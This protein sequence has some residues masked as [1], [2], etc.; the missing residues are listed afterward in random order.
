MLE[1]KQDLAITSR[2]AFVAALQARN[3]SR[4][5]LGSVADESPAIRSCAVSG[6]KSQ[7]HEQFSIGEIAFHEKAGRCQE[8][9]S[10]SPYFA[11]AAAFA[12]ILPSALLDERCSLGAQLGV[13]VSVGAAT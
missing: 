7:F 11:G 1:K 13:L 9:F 6:E 4:Y 10:L 8:Q 2:G 12:A 3:R 5:C